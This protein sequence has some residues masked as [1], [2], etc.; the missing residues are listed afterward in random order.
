MADAN[1]LFDPATTHDLVLAHRPE[2]SAPVE[3]VVSDVVWG[4]VVRL[5]RW[6]SA[7]TGGAPELEAGAWWRLAASCADL[8]RRLPGLS[9]EIAQP[10]TMEPPAAVPAGLPP[11][12][13]VALLTDRLAALLLSGRPVPL[14]A[15]ATEVDALGEAAIQ[16][17]A[18]RA[19]HPGGAP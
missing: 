12:A 14:R 4:E 2:R 3:A 5:L 18:D 11:A 6:A 16:A 9:A 10:W 8:L 17:L 19:L 13:R 15:L 7:G 1:W